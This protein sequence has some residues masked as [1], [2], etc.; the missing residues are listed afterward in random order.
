[1]MLHGILKFLDLPGTTDF[2]VS[3]GFITILGTVI[4][5]ILVK[6]SF[7]SCHLLNSS[8]SHDQKIYQFIK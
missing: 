5:P 2:F 3:L 7:Y 4:I 1:M 6:N 8:N